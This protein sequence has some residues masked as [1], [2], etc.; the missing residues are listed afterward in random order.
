LDKENKVTVLEEI[1]RQFNASWP[2]HRDSI[3][4][5]LSQAEL[6]GNPEHLKFLEGIAEEDLQSHDKLEAAIKEE[7][8]KEK[9]RKL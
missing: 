3:N 5:I 2:D 7:I 6:L 9:S 1:L 4:L 8:Q